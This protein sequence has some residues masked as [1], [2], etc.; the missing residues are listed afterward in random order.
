MCLAFLQH[1][2]KFLIL[3]QL[4]GSLI[5]DEVAVWILWHIKGLMGTRSLLGQTFAGGVGG[6]KV[7]HEIGG[8]LKMFVLSF[9]QH[10]GH[11]DAADDILTFF[12]GWVL[13]KSSFHFRHNVSPYCLL[14]YQKTKM[15]VFHQYTTKIM[16]MQDK[17]EEERTGI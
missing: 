9:F 10:L 14:Y 12:T 5:D 11:K 6:L 13:A 4:F 2:G 7:F 8:S 17:K 3:I 16:E 15:F 1:E